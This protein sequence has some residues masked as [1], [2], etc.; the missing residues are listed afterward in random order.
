MCAKPWVYNP[1]T[2]HDRKAAE[3][4][5]FC[6]LPVRKPSKG[7]CYLMKKTILIVLLVLLFIGGSVA[8][9][10]NGQELASAVRTALSGPETEDEDDQPSD[11][12]KA[13]HGVLG[14]GLEPGEEGFGAAVAEQAQSGE[15]G[16]K[17]SEAAKS[18]GKGNKTEAEDEDEDDQ[19]SDVANAVHEA[20]GGD[21]KPGDEGFGAAVAEQA[22]EGNLGQKVSAAARGAN[23][24]A[25]AGGNPNR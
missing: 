20:L 8:F 23:G 21:L 6:C 24:S 9:A 22:R 17:V 7:G 1:E 15:L 13:V 10:E 11:V 12:A 25:N 3:N 14:G 2:D 19:R 5:L 18:A 16:K 4:R